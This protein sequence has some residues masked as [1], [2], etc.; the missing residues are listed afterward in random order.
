[1]R[2]LICDF[3]GR[4]I[5]GESDYAKLTL[6]GGLRTVERDFHVSCSVRVKN[7]IDSFCAE[8]MKKEKEATFDATW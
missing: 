4:E 3:C 8:E 6:S 7:K 1:M 2:K 5:D